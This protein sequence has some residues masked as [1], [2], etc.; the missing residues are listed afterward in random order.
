MDEYACFSSLTTKARNL[1]DSCEQRVEAC[2]L[3][4]DK[5]SIRACLEESLEHIE[6][7]AEMIRQT[8]KQAPAP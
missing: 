4:A 7:M 8:L 5:P 3:S 2:I 1:A 6:S